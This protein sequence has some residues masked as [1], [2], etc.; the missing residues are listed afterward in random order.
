MLLLSEGRG[1]NMNDAT[2]DDS[3]ITL[4]GFSLVEHPPRIWRQVCEKL[5]DDKDLLPVAELLA[6]GVTDSAS[7]ASALGIGLEIV[8]IRRAYLH[9][10]VMDFADVLDV[11]ASDSRS[12]P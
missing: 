10:R 3:R 7:I 4:R 6:A 12:S 1:D 5:S 2:N 8:E 9:Q 11:T